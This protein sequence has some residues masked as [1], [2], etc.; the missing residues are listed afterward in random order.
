MIPAWSGRRV[1][2]ARA[3]MA[4]YLPAEC[5]ADDHADACPGVI[6]GTDPT[7]WVVGHV[8]S[9]IEHPELTWRPNNWRI[10]ARVC[11]DKSGP[12]TALAKARADGRREALAE[13][14]AIDEPAIV[15]AL[16]PVTANLAE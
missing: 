5:A 16:F 9:R 11:S 10:E 7:A 3:F 15:D 12:G 4:R 13:I 2:Q 6:D 1:Q 8:L 14:E